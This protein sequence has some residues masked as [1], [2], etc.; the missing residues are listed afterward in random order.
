[1]AL[2]RREIQHPELAPQTGKG[3]SVVGRMV[4]Q[5]GHDAAGRRTRQE[6]LRLRPMA[7]VRTEDG[8]LRLHRGAVEGVRLRQREPQGPLVFAEQ[9]GVGGELARVSHGSE[10]LI[11]EIVR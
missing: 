4:H 6:G 1:M 10:P 2:E 5:V 11:V 9:P 3:A 7:P 8:L